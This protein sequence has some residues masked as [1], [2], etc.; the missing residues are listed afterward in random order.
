A[1]HRRMKRVVALKIMSAAALTQTGSLKRFLREAQAAAKLNHPNIV[2]A[3]DAN[4]HDGIHYLAMEFV[5]GKDLATV[6]QE[7][8]R[9]PIDK[10]VDYTLQVARGLQYAHEHGVVHRDIKPGN[11]LLDK[12]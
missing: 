5:D 1:Q 6:V 11:L 4:D 2:T 9:L 10:A 12:S 3:F 7:Q 8:G